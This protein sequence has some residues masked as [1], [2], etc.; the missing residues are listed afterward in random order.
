MSNVGGVD[1]ILRITVGVVLL[2]LAVLNVLGPWAYLG[3]VP[4]LTGLIR[5]CPLYKLIGLNTCPIQKK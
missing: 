2:V 4:L 5:Y 1:R 3:I